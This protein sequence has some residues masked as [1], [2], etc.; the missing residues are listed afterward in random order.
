MRKDWILDGKEKGMEYLVDE[1]VLLKKCRY[2][3]RRLVG[4]M[5]KVVWR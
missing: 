1:G 5:G 3:W 2:C 4:F